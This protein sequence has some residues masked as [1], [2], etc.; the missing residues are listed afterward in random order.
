MRC[1]DATAT[2]TMG[3]PGTS[4]PMRWMIVDAQKRPAR[5]RLVDCARDLAFRH[6]GIMFERERRQIV[7][8]AHMA[9]ECHDRADIVRVLRQ[10]RDL[11]VRR[12]TRRSGCG[13]FSSA[14]HRRE[15]GDLVA[16]GDARIEGDMILIDGGT[17]PLR[18]GERVRVTRTAFGRATPPDRRRSP[19]RPA[20]RSSLRFLPT[21]CRTQAK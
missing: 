21:F 7:V 14:R 20:T 2:S 6:A 15:K 8:A 12:R 11:G 1:V 3:S 4:V 9:G 16:V 18:I 5:L 17:Q 10:R 13:S 19:H